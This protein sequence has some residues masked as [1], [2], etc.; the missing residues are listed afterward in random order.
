M[1]NKR[2]VIFGGGTVFHVRSHLAL[3]APAYGGT[4][5]RLAKLAEEVLP[6]MDVD[7][8]LTKMAGG[9]QLETNDDI[10]KDIDE[11]VKD[12]VTK[13]VILSAALCDY[14][15]DV[16]GG[17][18]WYRPGAWFG[19]GP[20]EETSDFKL[21]MSDKVGKYN[22]RLK[23]SDGDQALWL[24]PAEKI[25]NRVRKTRKDI[26]LVAFKTTCGAT[27]E[28][29]YLAGLELCKKSSCNLVFVND[30][31]TR[32]NM[33]VVPEEAT[34]HI[35]KDR[36]KALRGLL[37]LVF[38]RTHLTFTRSSVVG[39]SP[40]PWNS[41]EVPANLRTVVNHCI[42][43]NAYKPFNGATAGHF[44]VKVKPNE[45]LSSI[46]KTNFNKLEEV[47]LVRVVTDGPDNVIAFGAKPS[48][49]GQSQRIIFN[50]HPDL[51]CIVHFHC[52]IK[53]G[54]E[55]PVVSQYQFECGSHECG[56]NTSN[57]LKKFGNLS[58]VYLDNHGPNIAFNRNIDPQE[59]IDFIE[60]NFDL[61]QKTG[62]FV[63]VNS[64]TDD[65]IKLL[66]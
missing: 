39:G 49:G 23:T 66:K 42:E 32:L 43:K 54:S 21:T 62:G 10:A 47:G 14:V 19:E 24:S 31:T 33:I 27:Q 17:K 26:F 37:D 50:E 36:E 45:F 48:V 46:R 64:T 57:G 9:Q 56:L 3:C 30:V 29:Q 11:I 63:S 34:Y 59:V 8:R 60:N 16:V 52:P 12:D 51:D 38:Y 18:S 35:T 65:A 13:V 7:L 15:G 6:T 4:A 2:I 41:E 44:A 28:Q 22:E 5:K 58:A 1:D 61:S 53:E 20:H 40:V 25:I 55:V